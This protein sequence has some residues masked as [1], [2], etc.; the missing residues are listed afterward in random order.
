MFSANIKRTIYPNLK[1][2]F[3]PCHFEFS[4]I[5]HKFTIVVSVRSLRSDTILDHRV[6]TISGRKNSKK[7]FFGAYA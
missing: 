1:F 3:Y 4:S 7:H 5:N 6:K 2:L